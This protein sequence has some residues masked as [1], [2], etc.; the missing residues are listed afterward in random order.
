MTTRSGFTSFASTVRQHGPPEQ[1]ASV[2]VLT[3]DAVA[4]PPAGHSITDALDGA[5]QV[6]A[7][8]RDPRPAQPEA[9]A[10][11]EPRETRLPAHHVLVAGVDRRGPDAHEHL[12]GP[13]V[14]WA[15]A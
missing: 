5:G 4:R 9:G 12:A 3:E 13:G 2:A 6:G 7:A 1:S 14:G 10:V 11:E 8:G 15:H